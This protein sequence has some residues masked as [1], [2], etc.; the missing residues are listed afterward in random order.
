ML[1]APDQVRLTVPVPIED[2]GNLRA[3]QVV[4]RGD[5]VPVG[6]G[7]VDQVT[8]QRAVGD[9]IAHRAGQ[10]AHDTPG[11]Q[12]GRQLGVV[13]REPAVGPDIHHPVGDGR[14]EHI[15]AHLPGRR[16]ADLVSQFTQQRGDDLCFEV[17][18][19][20]IGSGHR[21]RDTGPRLRRLRGIR[22][23]GARRPLSA[24]DQQR[25]RHDQYQ[26]GAGTQPPPPQPRMPRHVLRLGHPSRTFRCPR[27]PRRRPLASRMGI[28]LS[29]PVRALSRG[30]DCEMVAHYQR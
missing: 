10:V 2:R 11:G 12:H 22:L 5:A 6:G 28:K 1:L 15:R 26:H 8:E 13:Q 7:L 23:G 30:Q 24:A 3:R 25:G 27:H 16:R 21:D 17:S 20:P 14:I 4:H 18:G 19:G 9:H 29:A